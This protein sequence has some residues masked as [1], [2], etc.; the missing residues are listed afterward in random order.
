[1]V[2]VDTLDKPYMSMLMSHMVADT[3]KE[4]I[5][6]ADKIGIKERWIQNY[7]KAKEHFDVSK[8]K[9]EMAIK[10]GAKL[11]SPKEIVRIINNRDLIKYQ[12]G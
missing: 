4:L 8:V 5:D 11:V 7:G 6:M 2:Y 9:K 10:H 12:E 3:R 1:M